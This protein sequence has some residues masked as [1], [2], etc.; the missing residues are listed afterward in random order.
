MLKLYSIVSF[1]LPPVGCLTKLKPPMLPSMLDC[2]LRCLSHIRA[3]LLVC[4][5]LSLCS[6]RSSSSQSSLSI[7]GRP[8]RWEPV[9]VGG[10]GDTLKPW[11]GRLGKLLLIVS[12]GGDRLPV[13]G[14]GLTFCD[15]C[16]R[17]FVRSLSSA[18]RRKN[19]ASAAETLLNREEVLPLEFKLPLPL[20]WRR[21]CCL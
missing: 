6:I 18:Y 7:E 3:S 21:C 2:F 1:K 17:M 15:A 10:R 12:L 13:V 11:Y 19:S 8:G 20:P 9:T 5:S 14:K 16:I 4:F